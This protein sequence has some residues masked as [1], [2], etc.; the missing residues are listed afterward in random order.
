MAVLIAAYAFLTNR[1]VIGR[2]IYAVGG[3]RHA[4]SFPA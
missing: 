2:Q 1:T 3:N 4:A